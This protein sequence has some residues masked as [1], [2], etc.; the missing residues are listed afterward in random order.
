MAPGACVAVTGLGL[1]TPGGVGVA[2]TW[3]AVC[4]GVS[5]AGRDASLAGLPVDIS[6]A[7]RAFDGDHLLGRRLARRMS[8]GTQMGVVAAREAV[9]M[10]GLREGTFDPVRAGV[11]FGATGSST[12]GALATVTKLAAGRV[13]TISPVDALRSVPSAC[14]TEVALDLGAAGPSF[15]TSAG[16]ASALV[17]IGVARDL[18]RAGV[19]DVAVVGGAE[20]TCDRLCVASGLSL[21]LLSARVHAPQE[22]M[23]PFDAGRDGWV[24]AEGAGVLVLERA[25]H[26]RGRGAR[27]L[28]WV[29]GFGA[30]GDV[31]HAARPEGRGAEQ[32]AV[33]ALADAGWPPHE[34]EHVNAHGASSRT[35]DAAEARWLDRLF[36]HRPP[37]TATK[38]VL[39]HAAAAS[40]AIEA[41]LTVL[42]LR[43]RRIPPIANLDQPDPEFRLHTVAKAPL[44]R[45]LRNALC[46]SAAMGGQNCSLA[47]LAPTP[48]TP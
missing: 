10:A 32:A 30:A 22:A 11:V 12:E 47:L 13:E 31:H 8:R 45:P 15:A 35:Y 42:T 28:S 21:G 20:V 43:H 4:E 19:L 34:V 6:C 9:R 46:V 37:V 39:G 33:L 23:R 16:C 3:A 40:G 2:P 41:A 26:A 14:P 7:V 18:L 24:A 48:T 25:E 1:V 17:A 36:P 5:L 44:D 38:G 29:A 27:V